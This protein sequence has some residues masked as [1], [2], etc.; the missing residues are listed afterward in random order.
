MAAPPLLSG[1]G[2]RKKKVL[3][4][5]GS[6]GSIGTSTLH[7]L[8]DKHL[9]ECEVYAGTRDPSRSFGRPGVITVEASMH[10]PD[11]SWLAPL[12]V[13]ILMTP[14]NENRVPATIKVATA[15]CR[16]RVPHLVVVSVSTADVDSVFGRQ[17][18]QIEEAVRELSA[19]HGTHYTLIRMPLFL[20]NYYGF[21]ATVKQSAAI[22][23]SIDPDQPYSPTAA[24][25]IGEAIAAVAAD[26]SGKWQD[27]TINLAG[28][29]HTVGQATE[30]LSELCGAP[31]RFERITP[32]EERA[33]FLSHG[34]PEWQADGI[35]ELYSLVSDGS[36][37]FPSDDL[38]ECIG[39]QPT[40][41]REYLQ[42]ALPSFLPVPI[43]DAT[44]P[45]D[46]PAPEAAPA[47]AAP[48]DTAVDV[49]DSRPPPSNPTPVAEQ[50]AEQPPR[51]R[52]P[53]IV[54]M[55]EMQDLWAEV[56]ELEQ[57]GKFSE[58]AA[59]QESAFAA[60]QARYAAAKE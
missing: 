12:D 51:G 40:S 56:F 20:E 53:S 10:E 31:I 57:Q 25:D 27:R 42:K 47:E 26:A 48:A 14:A 58:A 22:R 16:A 18:K 41:V 4:L 8:A 19:S 43:I 50:D 29:S 35:V 37:L 45:A 13:L 44:A 39:R 23:C 46:A 34:F 9:G 6:G 38:R 15:A 28:E 30:W 17:Y 36:Y 59:H 32:D 21:A 52:Q 3:V 11:D 54:L 2:D 55:E 60:A 1:A 7:W 33:M 5:G 24:N 49:T